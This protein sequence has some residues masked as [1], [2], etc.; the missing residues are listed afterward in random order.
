MV[1][2]AIQPGHN[3]GVGGGVIGK[4]NAATTIE[5]IGPSAAGQRIIAGRTD[6]MLII[7]GVN[8]FPSQIEEIVLKERVFTPNYLIEVGRSGHMDSM[9]VHVEW[10]AGGPIDPSARTAAAAHLAH[11]VKSSVGISIH[12]VVADPGTLERSTGKARRVVDRR[13]Q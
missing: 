13:T 4:I 6:D 10:P 8:V 7:R 2:A 1:D 11:H 5:H 3:T 12:V 9:T